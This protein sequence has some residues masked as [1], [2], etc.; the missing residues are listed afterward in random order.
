MEPIEFL[1]SAEVLLEK[2]SV[3]E[4]ECRNAAS[5]AYYSAYHSCVDLSKR[6]PSTNNVKSEGGV[7]K[8]FIDKLCNYQDEQMRT[9][10]HSLNQVK[11]RRVK[12]DYKLVQ[13]FT[14]QD[15][16]FTVNSVQKLLQEIGKI[17]P[18]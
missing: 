4:V 10:G 18:V 2:E 17:Q 5:R 13:N 7:H 16:K 6:Y 15:A 3:A 8:Q 9:V 14:L 1:K 11:I 12:A